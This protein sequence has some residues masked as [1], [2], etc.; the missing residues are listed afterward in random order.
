[1]KFHQKSGVS[2]KI[3]WQS[4]EGDT[5][6]EL[7]LKET[8]AGFTADS[9]ITGTG[10]I[11]FSLRYC[12]HLDP[13]WRTRTCMLE[14]EGTKK[15]LSLVSDG[16]GNW[17]DALGPLPELA[18]AIDVD[19]SLTPFTNTLPIRRLQLREKQSEEILVVY[20]APDL[21]VTMDR[22]RYTCLVL[23]KSYRFE[24]ID[25]GFAR[26]IEVDN[27]GLVIQYPDLFRRR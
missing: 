16:S 12:I 2:M 1:M 4:W 18:G 26:T 3:R 22:Q 6:E 23:G 21:T 11:P 15:G 25:S 27:N 9:R 17:T 13:L 8:A 19:I 5:T 7:L 10:R 24:Q 20:I 14:M